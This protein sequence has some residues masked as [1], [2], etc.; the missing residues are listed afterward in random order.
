[1]VNS[2]TMVIWCPHLSDH[3]QIVRQLTHKDAEW[4]WTAQHDEALLKLKRTIADTP[5]LKYYCP[6]VKLTLQCDASEWK[7]YCF[8]KQ[9]TRIRYAVVFS[10]VNGMD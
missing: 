7:A 1:M 9:S 2:V 4:N 10:M 3:C 6:N 5:V 8:C